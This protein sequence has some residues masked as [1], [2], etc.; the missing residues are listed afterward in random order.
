MAPSHKRKTI[1]DDDF[2]HTISDNDE[3]EILED[4]DEVVAA[5]MRP[6]KKA[7]TSTNTAD[8]GS[9][10]KK[11]KTKKKKKNKKGEKG[12]Q[13][14][15]EDAQDN[16]EE[17][18]TGLWGANDADD[19]AMNSDFEFTLGDGNGVNAFEGEFDGWG[20]E[21][22]KKGIE[23]GAAGQEG[24]AGVDLDEI[25][26]RRREKKKKTKGKEKGE[27][28]KED[29]EDGEDVEVEDMGEVD[30]DDEV[31]ADDAFGMGVEEG[32]GKDRNGEA[33]DGEDAASDDDSVATPVPHP[34]DEK[35]DDDDDDDDDEEDAEEEAKRKE[36]FAAPEETE[37]ATKKGGPSSF[38]SMSLSRP[39]LRGLTSV[40]FTKPTPIQAK[41]IPIA[42]M[43]KDVVGG[44]VTGSGKTA[45]FIVPIL[46]RLLYRPKKVP[47]TRVVILTPTRELAIQC[48]SVA[49]KLASHTDIKFCLAVGGLSLKVQEGELRL[50]P[51]VVIATPGRF[52]DH[53]RNSASFAVETV[54]ILVL[55]EADRM[56][57][58]GFADEL[59]EILTTLPKSRQTMLFSATMTSTVDK[60]IRVGLNK[61]ARIMVDSQK[62]TAG[63]LTQEFVRLR[64]GREE[65]RMG[66]EAFRDGKVNFLLATDLASRGL[67]IKGIDTVI[68][69]EAPQSLEIYV[70]RVGRTAR[71]GRSGVALTLAAEPDRKVVK[72]AVK[73]GKAQ[74]AKII[75][76][77]IDPA[78]ADKWQAQVDEMDEEIEEI[79]REEKEEKQLAQMEMQVKKGENLIKYEEEIHSRPK[80]TWF[81]SQEAKKKAKELGRAELNGIREA[82]KKK[83]GGKLSNKDKKKLDAKAERTEKK[84]TGWKK[85]R[86][87]RDGKGA[88]LNLKKIRKPK[89]KKGPRLLRFHLDTL[90]SYKYR[91]QSRIYRFLV[92]RQRK[93]R[94]RKS[95]GGAGAAGLSGI[96]APTIQSDEEVTEEQRVAREAQEIEKRG[97]DEKE[98]ANRGGYSEPPGG[99]NGNNQA[100]AA[101]PSAS[102]SLPAR[103]PTAPQ[104]DMTEQEL[105]VANANLM[106]RLGPFMTTPL[107]QVPIT[108]FFYNEEQS[109]SHT[110]TTDDSGHFNVRVPLEFV[111]TEVRVIA[112][113][114]LS[115][116]RP[117]EVTGQK[118]IS[119]ISDVDD[120]IKQSNISMGARE[121]FR[122][123]LVRDL[124]DLT[125]DGVEKWYNKMH[126]M[127]VKLH[128][129]SN[130]PWQLYPVL[131]TF[132]HTAGLP[133]GSMHLKHYSGMLQGIFEPVAERKKGTLEAIIRDF[134]ERRFLLVGD[135]GEAD[136]EVYT[137]LAVANPG[138]IL[139]I[140]IRDVTTPAQ[141]GFFD[142]SFSV[143]PGQRS[144][145][146]NAKAMPGARSVGDQF[147]RKPPVPPPPPPP[148]PPPRVTASPANS[149]PIMGNLIDFG[150]PDPIV[151]TAATERLCGREHNRDALGPDGSSSDVA[152]R[153]PPPPRPV[154]PAALR[155][156]PSDSSSTN[157]QR[158]T[159]AETGGG[160]S[161]PARPR[162]SAGTPPPNTSKPTPPP[163][164]PRRRRGTAPAMQQPRS[165]GDDHIPDVSDAESLSAMPG[166]YPAGVA[167][168]A[169]P[170]NGAAAAAAVNK[171]VDLWLMRLARAHQT[172]DAQGVKLYTWR[173][174][175]DV[176]AEAE[177][178]VREALRNMDHGS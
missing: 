59:N 152:R 54:E 154:K 124:A 19:G 169:T 39:I 145:Q 40:G 35:S 133:Q 121:I 72:A 119:L 134:P 100:S 66:V 105:A 20:F 4:E 47:T 163:P 80:R 93:R 139:A 146:G 26:R 44:A 82:L 52:I 118:G 43:G 89:A 69:Y 87:E 32:E 170:P 65:K 42:L 178:L 160:H 33:E 78:E 34:D 46:E 114:N 56:L 16:D 126:D 76:R 90:S 30:L 81:E 49:T 14:G 57:E 117:I 165:T 147:E 3:P 101:S 155:S 111:P 74:G 24:K 94:H 85:G 45:A 143:N 131:A 158:T 17:E 41:T 6:S 123:A 7:K 27:D 37:K 140:F 53:M 116:I 104:L 132:L 95:I 110:V 15:E 102:P 161:L 115:A 142:S 167:D 28:S 108:M 106:A 23:G 79:L 48:H 103:T 164:P 25:I 58:D 31:L 11:D 148:P 138:R 91:L 88:V 159:S 50:R 173:R 60:L 13:D 177:G 67:D 68:N 113:E 64:P 129:C 71:A 99:S 175:Q 12:A 120:T 162:T 51:D 172:L 128:Y 2:I 5:A 86:A 122:N 21:G 176:I 125:V 97:Q 151:S 10:N 157:S 166:G 130:S 70:H 77:V 137:E 174:G 8:A 73:A 168:S 136:L 22:A 112:N 9:K 150:E 144:I 29:Q 153:K 96:P 38:Q 156:T 127:G 61:P 107:V 63:T 55:D 36:F 109:R 62:Q 84:S 171:K 92:E 135:S 83:G 75:S 98:V 18:E 149:G 141:T 1:P